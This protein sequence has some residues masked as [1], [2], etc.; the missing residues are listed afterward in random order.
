M[1]FIPLGLWLHTP[2]L[3]VRLYIW[4]GKSIYLSFRQ[5]IEG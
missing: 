3:T 2:D 1:F 4:K 5:D